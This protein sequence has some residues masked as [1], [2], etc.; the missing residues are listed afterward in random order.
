MKDIEYIITGLY[1]GLMLCMAESFYF[2][3]TADK[4]LNIQSE[5]VALLMLINVGVCILTV[6]KLRINS[7]SVLIDKYL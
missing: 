3:I 5:I 6:K 4:T 2:V 7:L 1:L